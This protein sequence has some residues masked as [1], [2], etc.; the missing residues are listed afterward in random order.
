MKFIYPSYM[1]KF[2][3]RIFKGTTA[4]F[5]TMQ[6]HNLRYAV[7]SWNHMNTIYNE[8]SLEITSTS[9]MDSPIDEQSMLPVYYLNKTILT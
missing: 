7:D 5:D 9:T 4:A 2:C 8:I 6:Y 1:L 3:S